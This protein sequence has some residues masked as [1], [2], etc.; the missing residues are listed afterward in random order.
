M[1]HV[2]KRLPRSC[3]IHGIPCRCWE[4]T[5]RTRST[6]GRVQGPNLAGGAASSAGGSSAEW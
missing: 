1:R 2:E 3:H 5:S 6:S 4:P